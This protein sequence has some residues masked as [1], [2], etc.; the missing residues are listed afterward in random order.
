MKKGKMSREN[1]TLNEWT[2]KFEQSVY[3]SIDEVEERIMKK[4]ADY[5]KI[6]QPCPYG[7]DNDEVINNAKKILNQTTYSFNVNIEFLISASPQLHEHFLLRKRNSSNN[8][9]EDIEFGNLSCGA[10]YLGITND[11]E[12][13]LSSSNQYEATPEEF[14]KAT[15][16]ELFQSV[17]GEI[18]GVRETFS[19]LNDYVKTNLADEVPRIVERLIYEFYT[20][21]EPTE[22][23][24]QFIDEILDKERKALQER[25]PAT[26]G[27]VASKQRSDFSV[28]RVEFARECHK[29]LKELELEKLPLNKNRLAQKLFTRADNPLLFLNRKLKELD[30]SFEKI[31]KHY[32]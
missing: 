17:D 19:K 24:E 32:K 5:E 1:L 8:E 7:H 14:D 12:V 25:I 15:R 10:S 29:K 18:E 13:N 16:W 27:R 6:P 31:L 20:L 23:R 11:V 4:Y 28:L 26:K 9:S 2:G 30:L 22:F 21:N 3:P